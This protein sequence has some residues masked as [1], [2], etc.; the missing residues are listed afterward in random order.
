MSHDPFDRLRDA[1]PVP[2]DALP[3][4]PMGAADRIVAGRRS[5]GHWPSWAVAAAAALAVTVVGGGW[6]LW[7]GRDGGTVEA[8]DPSS[9]TA[10]S[11]VAPVERAAAVY[12]LSSTDTGAV[13]VPVP[14]T[15]AFEAPSDDPEGGLFA[16][17]EATLA[18]LLQTPTADEASAGLWNAIPGGIDGPP[19][20][21]SKLTRAGD[22]PRTVATVFVPHQ[23]AAFGYPDADGLAQI[24]FT[25]TRIDGIDAVAFLL[26]DSRF[27]GGVVAGSLDLIPESEFGDHPFVDEK[28]TRLTFEG[29]Q[30]LAFVD[31]PSFG[32]AIDLPFTASGVANSV[33][34]QVRLTLEVDEQTLW[35]ETVTATCGTPWSECRGEWDWGVWQVTIP[36]LGY[37][38]RANLI[39]EA[40]GSGVE[41]IDTRTTPVVVTS[42]GATA[43]TVPG[44]ADVPAELAV[45]LLMD[46]DA[47]HLTPGPHLVPV[48]WPT[49]I[50]SYPLTDQ[51]Y[52]ALQ[53]LL[54]GPTPGQQASVPAITTAIPEGTRLLDLSIAGDGTADVDLSGE[55][56]S[57][58][59]AASMRT[60]L[61][62]VVFTLTRFDGIDAVR[63]HVDGSA[64][65]YGDYAF[66]GGD[67]AT[68][69]DFD[70][71][72]PPIMI[73]SPPYWSV[74]RNVPFTASGTADVFEATVSMAL[75]DADG[76]I[77]W[78]GFATATCGTGCRGDWTVEIPYQVD[79]DQRGSLIVW[80]ASARDGSQTNV[81]EHPVWLA[82]TSEA[83]APACSGADVPA[84]LPPQDLPEAVAE[85]R[86]SLF[87]AARACDWE[88]LSAMVGEQSVAVSFGDP[89]NDPIAWL[90]DAEERRS[91]LPLELE[92]GPMWWL[93]QTLRLPASPARAEEVAPGA[94]PPWVW[95]AAFA[96][97]SW[98]AVSDADRQALAEIYDQGDLDGYAG[99]GAFI[100][101]RVGIDADGTWLFFVVGD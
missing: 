48:A 1:N 9:T 10:A 29:Y 63:L 15:V 22:D 47:T 77:L 61:A 11:V 67:T 49:A 55:F 16:E 68:R 37:T 62:Q 58:G 86:E 80:E 21:V 4:A 83:A 50:L 2:D 36:D 84:D 43:T 19:L 27:T 69:A 91:D 26:D 5:R 54:Q 79:E 82:A 28:V 41:V 72:L 89:V 32:A 97:D 23:W 24:V 88:A 75:T 45:Y 6:L 95:P 38:G 35:Q 13:V 96:A 73:E 74:A 56:L 12:L 92:R 78:E 65:D 52:Q 33:G 46:A 90:R 94:E 39:A 100:G 34:N 30:S 17:A 60:R 40:F 20:S 66:G 7:L 76:L 42:A 71:L 14:R 44:P 101:Y 87:A 85:A 53:W 3:S 31:S 98:D 99:F 93:A 57:D 18:A 8:A 51:P 25:L 64:G 81:R 70:D 59:D